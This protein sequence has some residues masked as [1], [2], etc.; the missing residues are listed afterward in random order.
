MLLD[1][2]DYLEI[3][4]KNLFLFY[5]PYEQKNGYSQC[6]LIIQKKSPEISRRSKQVGSYS[7]VNINR[8]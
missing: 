3:N 4:G 1:D 6:S 8:G 2:H 7:P 5:S